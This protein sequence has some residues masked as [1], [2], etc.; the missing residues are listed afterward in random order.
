MINLWN[1]LLPC[2][3]ISLSLFCFYFV[4]NKNVF[5]KELYVPSFIICLFQIVVTVE[6]VA[7]VLEPDKPSELCSIVSNNMEMDSFSDVFYA[8]QENC[9]VSLLTLNSNED[10]TDGVRTYLYQSNYSNYHNKKHLEE[11]M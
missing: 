9:M 4:C 11:V 3:L 7:P 1:N 5:E 6:R 2:K 8:H 10:E